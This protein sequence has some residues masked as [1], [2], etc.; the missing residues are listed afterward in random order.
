MRLRL[1]TV[2]LV[3]SLASPV[4]AGSSRDVPAPKGS[5]DYS[6][7]GMPKPDPPSPRPIP[8]EDHGIAERGVKNMQ[9][10]P[11]EMKPGVAAKMP[12][13]F[14]T[15][16]PGC[17]GKIEPFKRGQSEYYVA[18]HTT[19]TCK[20]RGDDC[21]CHLFRARKGTR[22]MTHIDGEGNRRRVDDEMKTHDYFCY[23]GTM[24]D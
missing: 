7:G 22:N 21:R 15:C 12:D 1:L 20:K 6:E 9:R 10:T 11:V 13:D 16:G 19:P 2:L 23:C 3:A 4:F 8:P 18:C 24:E 17:A 14:K 5:P